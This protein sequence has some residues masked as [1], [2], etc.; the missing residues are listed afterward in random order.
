[1]CL[2]NYAEALE[3]EGT[4]GE[5]AKNAWRKAAASLGSNSPIATCPRRYNMF[6]RLSDKERYDENGQA[7]PG[8]LGQADSRRTARTDHAGEDRHAPRRTPRAV[9]GRPADSLTNAPASSDRCSPCRVQPDSAR[10]LEIADRDHRARTAPRPCK[11]A[12]E[13]TMRR[14]CS[15]APSTSIAT[16]STTTTGKL[17]CEIEPTD[18]TLEARKTDLRCRRGVPRRASS[19]SRETAM[20]RAWLKWRSVLDAH[21]RHAQADPSLV[22]ELIDVDRPLS[23]PCCTSSTSRFRRAVRAAA[24]CSK[25]SRAVLAGRCRRACKRR[26]RRQACRDQT[27]R[28]QAVESTA[29]PSQV[30]PKEPSA[31]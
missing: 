30:P 22:D 20:T 27:C 21:P 6:V 1:M 3:E 18:D 2:I 19:S 10:T 15:P 16:S 9:R 26:G 12:E 11:R 23:R 4:F 25:R 5:V 7:G 8:E 14:R 13:A 31:E 24:T 17:R 28:D 29:P